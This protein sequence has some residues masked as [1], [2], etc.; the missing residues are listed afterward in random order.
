MKYQV[1][2]S[3]SFINRD[4]EV[5]SQTKN[6]GNNIIL[7]E[8]KIKKMKK[9]MVKH[10]ENLDSQIAAVTSSPSSLPTPANFKIP[11]K[12]K[13]TSLLNRFTMFGKTVLDK[14]NIIR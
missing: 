13:K 12:R 4:R 2:Q 9:N 3:L 5:R 8:K 7:L 6:F 1:V 11:P 14:L 10:L